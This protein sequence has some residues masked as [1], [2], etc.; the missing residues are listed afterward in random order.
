[1]EARR[2]ALSGTV[3]A[4]KRDI[5]DI[6]NSGKYYVTEELGQQFNVLANGLDHIKLDGYLMS[7]SADWQKGFD[8]SQIQAHA[9]NTTGAIESL[10]ATLYD[11]K[12]KMGNT[13]ISQ[14]QENEIRERHHWASQNLRNAEKQLT[15][16]THGAADRIKQFGNHIGVTDRYT[17]YRNNLTRG[18]REPFKLG[19]SWADGGVKGGQLFSSF[20][21]SHT[22]NGMPTQRSVQ[23]ASPAS[24]R[25]GVT[26]PRKMD[27]KGY[28]TIDS[29]YPRS[30]TM[31]ADDIATSRS[32]PLQ[33]LKTANTFNAGVTRSANF[34]SSARGHKNL[35][36]QEQA[37]INMT[38]PGRTEYMTRYKSP[39]MD[40]ETSHFTINPTPNFKLH[41]RPL[42]LTGY[43]SNSTEYQVR[44]EWPDGNRI[45]KLPWRRN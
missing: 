2:G 31:I 13:S 1:M 7:T 8:S 40:I 22:F 21:R 28:Q 19:V 23:S 5:E 32:Q 3:N 26:Q 18:S 10:G 37:G 42:G 27:T 45:V 11:Y 43:D 38:F 29:I 33:S 15:S 36:V 4:I 12:S 17:G 39:P 34:L 30:N 44:Y 25:F 9:A 14:C 16:Y 24:V 35:C 6:C 41:G 20:N